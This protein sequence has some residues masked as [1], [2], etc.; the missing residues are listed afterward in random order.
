MRK[1][2]MYKIYVSKRR[3]ILLLVDILAIF[4]IM[5]P[6]YLGRFEAIV[7]INRIIKWAVAILVLFYYVV[8]KKKLDVYVLLVGAFEIFLLISTILNNVS[9]NQWFTNSAYVLILTL[10][11]KIMIDIDCETLIKA[12]SIVL[13]LYV[14]INMLT[15]ILYPDGL[16]T[17]KLVGY[18]N[19]WFLGYDNV[20]AIIIVL[21][22]TISVFR[23]LVKQ[24]RRK[25]WDMSVVISGVVFIFMQ[26]IAT[27]IIAECFFFIY[28]FVSKFATLRKIVCR[29]RIIVI[30]MFVLF[31]LIQA[32]NIQQGGLFAMILDLLGKD[33]TF[34]GR[35]FLWQKAWKDIF[36]GHFLYGFGVLDTLDYVR[37]YGGKAFSHLHCYYLQVLYEGGMI[38]EVLLFLMLYYVAGRY[39]KS[40]KSYP[41]SIFLGG[42]TTIMII[43]QV[44]AYMTVA[45]YFV[46]VL[47]LLNYSDRI[48]RAMVP[49]V[50][51]LS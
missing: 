46:I 11:V 27:A 10:F 20:S 19:C 18:K 34:T 3:N 31:I 36:S 40:S 25:I 43:W 13:G 26:Q 12:L 2:K 24:T 8:V 49:N 9:I 38:G 42:L 44:E 47:T 51:S 32:F 22:Q 30:S 23:M 16:F 50:H 29:A 4:S 17:D 5:M 21:S 7:A 15:R 33:M 28:I 1:E 35:A 48:E 45:T 41:S 6:S 39:D 14:H 37:I